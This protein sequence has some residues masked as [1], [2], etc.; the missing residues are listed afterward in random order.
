M[1]PE[2]IPYNLG[3]S[4]VVQA[5]FPEDSN[6]RNMP[7]QLNGVI[8]V[9]KANGRPAPVVLILHG[10]HPGC[11]FVE[12]RGIDVWPCDSDDEQN[13]FVG[14]SYLVSE[15][16]DR[17]YV[18][19]S[20][21]MNPQYTLGYGEETG[22][23][24]ARQLVE[25][26]LAALAEAAA[27]GE[28]DF[29]VELAGAA[30]LGRL[31]LIGHSQ[32]GE[33]AN[34]LTREQGW[35]QP[36]SYAAN[37]FG[38]VKGILLVAPSRNFADSAGSNVPI[39]AILP[40]CDGD[41]SQ[42]EGQSYIE[43]VRL[44]PTYGEYATAAFLNRGTH[45]AFNTILR[46]DFPLLISPIECE[47][48]LD[49]DTQR[50]FLVNYAADFLTALEG[51]PDEQL[52]SMAT[53][54]LDMTGAIP[55]N[56]YGLP[57]LLTTFA[58]DR[59]TLF[60]PFSDEELTTNLLGG[61]VTA[62]GLDLTYCPE[63]YFGGETEPELNN[64]RRRDINQPGNPQMAALSW[65]SPE[66]SWRFEIPEDAGDFSA[67]TA[68]SLRAAADPISPL[69]RSGT[70]QSFAIRLTDQSGQSAV[71]VVDAGEPALQLSPDEAQELGDVTIFPGH[72]YLATVR[73]PLTS[74]ADVDFSSIRAVALLFD[75]IDTGTLFLGDIEF[76][77]PLQIVGASSTLL[78]IADTA[79]EP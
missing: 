64:C 15:L 68:L 63:G 42:L 13:N 56:L 39:A 12:A 57:V 62:E 55:D 40:S 38:P 3:D 76:V 24:R 72:S 70:G 78:E 71:H 17:G 73:V 37:G 47:L 60:T 79:T 19:L 74:F 7:V 34:W 2:A 8:A 11:P 48:P 1:L 54:G 41:V 16:A 45:N 61:A 46:P 27:G 14:F 25:Q 30:D 43:V 65:E 18:A 10:N 69:N 6:F 21:N 51:Q 20:I 77:R 49:P 9:P 44:D 52:E 58:E 66:A 5:Q 4:T 33:V 35:D 59:V 67:Y 28:N 23:A 26:H 50:D 36:E 53:L 31:T 75:Q 32:G 22:S 29:G